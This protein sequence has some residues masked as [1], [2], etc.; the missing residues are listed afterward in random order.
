MAKQCDGG[1]FGDIG[2]R[3]YGLDGAID[4]HYGGKVSIL[5]SNPY[6]GGETGNLYPEG[7]SANIATFYDNITKGEFANTTVAPSIRSNLASILGRDAAY[8]RREFTWAE[9]IKANEK[10]ESDVIKGLKA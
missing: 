4:T 7:T 2:C 5:G 9:L 8:K 10:L 1:H 6:K 3:M